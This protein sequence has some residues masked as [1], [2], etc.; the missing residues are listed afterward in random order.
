MTDL[1]L[2]TFDWVP[3]M[4]RGYSCSTWASEARHCCPPIPVAAAKGS[5][6]SLP[7]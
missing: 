5:N 4:P 7:R 3:E 1:V 6:G 2:T